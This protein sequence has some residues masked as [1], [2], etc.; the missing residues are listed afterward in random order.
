[1]NRITTGW[2]GK[3]QWSEWKNAKKFN[4]DKANL[5]TIHRIK[6]D[7]DYWKD[8]WPPVRIRVTLEEV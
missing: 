2:V 1:M 3:L 6:H 7:Q 5:P 4:G 8:E